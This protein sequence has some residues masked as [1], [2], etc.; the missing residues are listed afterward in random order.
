M[1]A[2][3]SIVWCILM[4][5]SAGAVAATDGL[6]APAPLL[7]L[8]DFFAAGT[9]TWGFRVSPD[10]TAL[11][12]A[13]SPASR[14]SI[15]VQ[16]LDSKETETIRV[17]RAVY[18]LRW[19]YDN[20]HL[21]FLSEGK[22]SEELQLYRVDRLAPDRPA[23]NLT[24]FPGVTVRAPQMQWAETP[25]MLPDDPDHVLVM[26]NRRD[27][28]LFDLHRI[29]L[30][31]GSI[32]LLAENP[33]DVIRWIPD[34]A[35]NPVARMR[36]QPDGGWHL[37]AATADGGWRTLLQGDADAEFTTRDVS[38]DGQVTSVKLV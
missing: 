10:G 26:M 27:P 28:T 36:R 12:W 8:G 3:G 33:G 16:R 15:V 1:R 5:G 23:V 6:P 13:S 35:G 9:P 24:P 34:R 7:P 20:R 22:A 11:A 29:D 4:L 14:T 19:A 2:I 30:R 21:L 17:G 32:A 31:D 38:A 25:W 37:D 18:G